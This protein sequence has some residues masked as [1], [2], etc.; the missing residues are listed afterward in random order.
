M[1]LPPVTLRRNFSW[2]FIGNG[3]YAASQWGMLVTL[4]KLGNP[5]MVGQFTLG[6]AVTAPV[7]ML[8]NLQLR[9]VQA[10]DAKQ[11]YGFSDY[12]GLRI[13]S[14]VLALVTITGIVLAGQY[15]PETALT[16]WLI[17]L[18][19]GFEALSDICYGLFQQHEQM[20]WVARSLILKGP[21]S[22]IVL[23]I[24]VYLSGSVIWGVAGLAIVWASILFQYDFQNGRSISGSIHPHWQTSKLY[25]LICLTFPLG[26]VMM[27]ISLNLN[28]PRYLIE[29]KLGARELGIFSALS[30]LMVLGTMVINALGETA[31]PRLAKYYATGNRRAFQTLLLQLVVIA[32]L[33]GSAVVLIALVA[34]KPILMLLYQQEYA[35]YNHVFIWLMG[36]AGM[37][38]VASFLG[39]GMTAARY[40]RIQVPLFIS[41]ALVATIT[42]LWLL[43]TKGLQGAAIALL[44]AA[45]MQTLIS[46]GVIIHALCTINKPEALSAPCA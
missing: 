13:L 44:L 18:A 37:G 1:E 7:L 26:I 15:Q 43:P 14:T 46:T 3:V 24:I 4:V 21:I 2:A 41:T 31:S 30:Y 22:L 17:G 45:S 35:Q 6:F 29:W 5:E 10:T 36:A 19:K 42:C 16:I 25:Q 40:F 8:T 28:I 9:A 12:L 27:L 11:Q 23:A 20:E 38:Y 34:G 39:Y 32:V 33:I